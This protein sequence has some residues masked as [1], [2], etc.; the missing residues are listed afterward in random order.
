MARTA[1]SVESRAAE[2]HQ[3]EVGVDNEERHGAGSQVQ[4]LKRSCDMAFQS[5]AKESECAR[6]KG[7][8]R[9][10]FYGGDKSLSFRVK[11]DSLVCELCPA[12]LGA[13][14]VFIKLQRSYIKS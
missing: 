9:S 14:G 7:A 8:P 5:I 1:S 2:M 6:S 13:A 12:A 10:F 11:V 4:W 3:D